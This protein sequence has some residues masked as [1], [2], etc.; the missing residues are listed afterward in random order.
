[1]TR[2]Q[3]KAYGSYQENRVVDVERPHP[4]EGEVLVKMRAV[5]AHVSDGVFVRGPGLGLV[6]DGTWRECVT[7]PVAGITHMRAGINE[8]SRCIS[9]ARVV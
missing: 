8:P 4:K 5:C 2:T 1:M 9:R 3:S 7:S 6:A